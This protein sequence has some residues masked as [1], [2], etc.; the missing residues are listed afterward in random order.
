MSRI[1]VAGFGY[2][3]KN[4]I[5]NFHELG[6]LSL[7]CD[8]D[9]ARASVVAEL[10]PDAR[11]TTSFQDVLDDPEIDAV[12]LATPAVTHAALAEKVMAA[13]KDCFVE[14]PLSLSVADGERLN[15]V[16]ETTDRM[17]MVGHILHY[18]PAVIALK[19]LVSSGQL[20]RIDYIYSNRLN[21]GKFRTEENI[22]WSFAPHDISVIL[23]LLNEEPTQVDC[24]GA[25]YLSRNVADVTM[26]QMSFAS[27]AK[28]HIH[29]SWL[30][31]F[32]EHR[33]TV[34]GETGMAVFE[35]SEN[36]PAQK[37]RLY[38]HVVDTSGPV[39]T[40]TKADAEPIPYGDDEPLRTECSHFLT[41]CA[42]EHAALT[43]ADEALRVL[44]V[45]IQASNG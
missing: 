42:G 4:L 13:G 31:P 39:P 45:L 43:D 30:H 28:A 3:G 23:G 21:I 8:A 6:S 16:A 24:Q 34:V 25:S 29:V 18:H 14:K 36:D 35:D 1:A 38:R 2:W 15:Q 20:G 5:R 40:P 19:E 26:T 22:L 32:K 44:D 37:L 11:F 27:G 9:P 33:L 7:V 41:A 10:Y 17:L 12:A